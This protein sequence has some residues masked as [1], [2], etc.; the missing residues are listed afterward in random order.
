VGSYDAF[1]LGLARKGH[2]A[3]TWRTQAALGDELNQQLGT[4][5]Q[6]VAFGKP[7]LLFFMG[8]RNPTNIIYL[9]ARTDLA[10]DT[11]EPGGF[12]G[13]VASLKSERPALVVMARV[14]TR[15]FANHQNYVA[16]DDWIQADYVLLNSC[17]AAGGGKFY[18]RADLADARFAK[19][20]PTS[21]CFTL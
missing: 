18:I 7:E 12:R 10:A 17:R 20:S 21:K 15:R 13:M 11:F 2:A 4:N 14:R 16:L 5:A 8:R 19:P 6:V 1:V 9:L 3:P